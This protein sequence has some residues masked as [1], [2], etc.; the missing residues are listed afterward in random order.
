[1]QNHSFMDKSELGF[2]SLETGDRNGD[3]LNSGVAVISPTKVALPSIS[4]RGIQFLHPAVLKY[5][6]HVVDHSM[7]NHKQS[8]MKVDLLPDVGRAHFISLGKQ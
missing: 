8:N 1:M 2:F 3:G 5:R 7:L 6:N 4:A